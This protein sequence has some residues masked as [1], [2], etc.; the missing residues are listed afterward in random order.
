MNAIASLTE[1][2]FRDLLAFRDTLRRF[3]R[4]SSEQAR[5]VGLT[6]AQHQLSACSSVCH[7]PTSPS[8]TGCE[9]GSATCP[10]RPPIRVFD[11]ATHS[12][13]RG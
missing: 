2:E 4:W 11:A 3:M 1:R 9:A 12:D 5:E 7:R 10:H 6:P 8:S 13:V